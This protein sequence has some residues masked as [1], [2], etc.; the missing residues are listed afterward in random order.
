MQSVHREQ[1]LQSEGVG[2][3]RMTDIYSRLRSDFPTL[4]SLISQREVRG[5]TEHAGRP[6]SP[7]LKSSWA[8]DHEEELGD[9][10]VYNEAEIEL[11]EPLS[12]TSQHARYKLQVRRQHRG[13]LARMI[14]ELQDANDPG[15]LEP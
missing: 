12:R 4:A 5:L 6:F 1:H 9:A 13:Q 15:E 3:Y 10:L 8:V 14:R 11:L 7:T 2:T